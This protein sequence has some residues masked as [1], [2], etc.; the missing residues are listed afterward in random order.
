VDARVQRLLEQHLTG[1]HYRQLVELTGTWRSMPF[2]FDPELDAFQIRDEWL[3]EAFPDPDAI[4]DETV[5]LLLRAAEILT[6]HREELDSQRFAEAPAREEEGE[7]T[8]HFEPA[9]LVAAA[10]LEELLEHHHY[11]FESRD[12][13][14]GYTITIHYRYRTDH[15]FASQ[16]GHIQWLI[17]LARRLGGGRRYKAWRVT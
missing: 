8:V 13:P 14:A 2:Y 1:T 5:D 16:R 6:E 10:H 7:I 17:E 9:E 15:E 4:P 11:R 12:T 3:L